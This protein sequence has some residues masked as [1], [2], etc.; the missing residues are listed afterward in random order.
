MRGD[1]RFW[2]CLRTRGT[3]RFFQGLEL[4]DEGEVVL[5]DVKHVVRISAGSSHGQ[6]C[7]VM[8]GTADVENPSCCDVLFLYN[9]MVV[10]EERS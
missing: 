10:E 8:M 6:D 4:Q 7:E 2:K 1:F 9:S 5:A 3:L